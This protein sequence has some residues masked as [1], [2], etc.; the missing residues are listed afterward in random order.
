MSKTLRT[1]AM[2][3]FFEAVLSLENEEECFRFFEDICTVNELLSI[4]QRLEVAKMLTESH[5]YLDIADKTGAS[6]ATI[7]RVNRSL[8]YGSDGY[9][10]VLERMQKEK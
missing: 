1:E 2:S 3:Q 8:N 9:T 4:A 5:T 10:M 7:S 6:T